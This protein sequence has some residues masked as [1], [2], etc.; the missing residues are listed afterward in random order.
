MSNKQL[1][2]VGV[3]AAAAV[4]GYVLYKRHQSTLLA[5]KPVVTTNPD[6]RNPGNPVNV[7]IEYINKGQEVL[8]AFRKA[9]GGF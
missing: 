1:L 3:V 5:T 8:E 9:F 6:Q 7:G 4:G 2:L